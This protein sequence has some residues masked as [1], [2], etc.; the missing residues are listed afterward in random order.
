[1]IVPPEV[2]DHPEDPGDALTDEVNGTV[3]A[4][5]TAAMMAG[6]GSIAKSQECRDSDA[7][8]AF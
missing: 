2:I 3:G 1:L 7:T 8:I 5:S 4:A 6:T